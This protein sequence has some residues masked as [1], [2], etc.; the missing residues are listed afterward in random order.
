VRDIQ[1]L[2][3]RIDREGWVLLPAK[4]ELNELEKR[5]L[6]AIGVP[7][8]VFRRFPFWKSIGV[9]IAR[10]PGRSG[11]IGVNS[12][13]IDCVTSSEPPDF[14]VLHCVRP[15]PFAG[16]ESQLV[17]M[18]ILE[19]HLSA[20]A[21]DVL[22][23]ATFHEP[24]SF[25][26]DYVGTDVDPF[27]VLNLDLGG[28]GRY[29]W[30]G[31]LLESMNSQTVTDALNEASRLLQRSSTWALLPAGGTLIIDQARIAHGRSALGLGQEN[32]PEHHR[33]LLV[34]CFLRRNEVVHRG[35]Q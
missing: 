7:I 32:I 16:G 13:H 1:E 10:P 21:R 11:G 9:D 2:K 29:R 15:D 28:V 19:T 6:P 35:S 25:D 20:Q 30:T 12:L 22:Q 17:D 34:Q 4:Y 14:V 8:H 3:N 31:R 26:L 23:I 18:T 5:I 27:A 33:R 24:P